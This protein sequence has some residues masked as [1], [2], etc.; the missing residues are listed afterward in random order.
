[1]L[2]TFDTIAFLFVLSAAFGWVNSRYFG[3]LHSTSLLVTGL[4]VSLVIVA[5]EAIFP[6]GLIQQAVLSAVFKVDFTSLLMNGMLAFLLFAGA[7]QV[8]LG[9]LRRRAIPVAILAILATSLST[10]LVGVGFWT[11]STWLGQPVPMAWC[12]VFGALISP[13]DPV[14]VM[15]TL[16][17]V[18]L[19]K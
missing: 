1:M 8:D 14:A 7:L 13:T 5:L 11:V 18:A 4:L 16:K 2:S 6:A 10:G 15:S 3:L 9:V 12:L 19:P 17:S